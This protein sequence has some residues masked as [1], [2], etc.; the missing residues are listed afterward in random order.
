MNSLPAMPPSFRCAARAALPGSH[1]GEVVEGCVVR[2]EVRN[3]IG[4]V[5]IK[6]RLPGTSIPRPTD[7]CSTQ[8][9]TDI[10]LG[11]RWQRVRFVGVGKSRIATRRGLV[12]ARLIGR[13]HRVDGIE[14]RREVFRPE[15]KSW[16]CLRRL[17]LVNQ[18]Q[19]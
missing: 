15:T 17:I 3:G 8:Q 9:I 16:G 18:P 1:S 11:L 19:R 7:S 10:R 13:L 14:V 6:R 12:V 2:G 5:A 4:V